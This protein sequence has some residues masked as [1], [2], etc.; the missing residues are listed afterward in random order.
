MFERTGCKWVLK[1]KK[2][3]D[4][5]I[6]IHKARLVTKGFTQK[7]GIDYH[8]TGHFS[9]FYKRSFPS[10]HG[11]FLSFPSKHGSSFIMYLFIIDY[12]QLTF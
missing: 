6:D 2:N 12:I 9:C 10:N 4:G 3:A 7:E 11:S 8:E 1:T 5:Q